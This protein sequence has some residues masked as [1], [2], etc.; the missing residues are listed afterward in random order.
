MGVF[1]AVAIGTGSMAQNATVPGR[2]DSLSAIVEREIALHHIP[3]AVVLAGDAKGVI[4]RRAFGDRVSSP[5]HLPMTPDAIFD[6]ASLTKVIATTTAVMQLKERGLID[7]D[8]RVTNYWPGFG[9]H[10]KDSI[11]VRQLLTHMSGLRPDIDNAVV[12]SGEQQALA[13]IV[14]DHPIAPPGSR[15]IY[16]DLNFIVLGELVHRISGETLDRYTAE[17]IFE[18]LGMRDTSFNPAVAQRARG[19]CRPTVRPARCVGERFRTR[20]HTGWVESQVTRD[21]FRRPMTLPGLPG[22]C[23]AGARARAYRSWRRKPSHR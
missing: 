3:G 1:A 5:Q 14:S 10:G 4:Y 21:S 18:P 6:L 11:T 23:W 16:S 17:R 12:W 20:R 8:A 19:S 9:A 15:F 7:L 13:R 22:C 2:L